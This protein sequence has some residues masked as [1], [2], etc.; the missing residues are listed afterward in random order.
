VKRPEQWDK[1]KE[2]VGAALEKEVSERPAFLDDACAQDHALR[3]EVE[4]L[5][6][7]YEESDQLPENP[8]IAQLASVEEINTI[9]PYKLLRKLGEG[10]MGQ[11]WLAEQ[12][13]PVRRRVAL[14][15]IRAG[16][17]DES[18]LH[19]FQSEKQSL[20]MMEHPA[21]A[22]VFD[23][24]TTPAGQPRTLYSAV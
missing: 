10:G 24:G 3:A 19:R 5:V 14:K 20:A 16:M 4:S 15:L 2:L 7:A 18:V 8:W 9:G 12:T 11:V 1:I 13:A 23:A 6:A 17:Y 22:K 21:I